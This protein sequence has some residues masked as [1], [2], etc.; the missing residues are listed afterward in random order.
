MNR[1]GFTLIEL[2][3]TIVILSIIGGIATYGVINTIN[4]SKLKSEKIFV[5]KLSNLI[6]DYL[7]LYSPTIKTGN[8]YSFVKCKNI[9]CSEN[10]SITAI[11]MLK[12]NGEVIKISDLV[13]K[14]IINYEDLV[15][16]KNKEK[17][18]DNNANPEIVVYKDSDYVYH[19][20]VDLSNTN[21][22]CD[23][24]LEN[25]LIN[26]MPK[27]LTE[28]LNDRITLPQILIDTLS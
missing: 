28:V 12:A 13:D 27:K 23:I 4:T 16:P 20:Y 9:D 1:K 19:Y 24:T 14:H 5:D 22:K 7:D 25:A 2:L 21:T 6:D 18:F 17:C 3:A 15:N 10:Y 26:N 8:S 11:Q